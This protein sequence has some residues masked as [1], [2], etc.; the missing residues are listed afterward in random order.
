MDQLGPSSKL[1]RIKVQ[2]VYEV[3]TKNH[4]S[5]ADQEDSLDPELSL[6]KMSSMVLASS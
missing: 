3:E 1:D 6:A 4:G 2:S 5:S